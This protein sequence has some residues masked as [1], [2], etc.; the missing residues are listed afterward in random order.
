M[1]IETTAAY[2]ESRQYLYE[3]LVNEV[4]YILTEKIKETGIKPASISSRV[5]LL[6]SFREKISRKKYR[7][8]MDQMHDLAGVRVVCAY[9]SE[10]DT[11][12][13]IIESNFEVLERTDKAEELGVNKMGY[14]GRAFVVKLG[15]RYSGGRYEDLTSLRCEIQ[16]RTIL[17][18]AWAIIDHQLVY[19]DEAS[20]P[21]GMRRDINNVAS[22]LE[23]AQGVFDRVK[24][25]RSEYIEE[26]K[27]MAKNASAFLRLPL[28]FDTVLEYARRSYPDIEPSEKLTRLL[29]DD[30]SMEKYPTLRELDCVVGQAKEAVEVYQQE[31]PDWFKNSTDFLT[32]SLGFIDPDFRQNHAFAPRTR[33]AFEKYQHLLPSHD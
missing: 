28:N 11:I 5:K 19:K 4:E 17:Q 24:E 15:S 33:E 9:Q 16:Y 25:S 21:E 29:L 2:F 6:E 14:S 10:L 1:D 13:E 32:K 27:D 22:L 31:N 3:K 7:N 26:I 12:A 8:P 20:V 30:L 18:D 23:V